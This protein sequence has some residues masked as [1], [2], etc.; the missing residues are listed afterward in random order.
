M[1]P[2]SPGK[3]ITDKILENKGNYKLAYINKKQA[4]SKNK[5]KVGVEHASVEDIKNAL[6]SV[7]NV[8]YKGSSITVEQLL[9]RKLINFPNSALMRRKVCE[10]LAI[11]YAN[12]KTFLKYLN[13][14]GI[15]IE[16]IDELIHE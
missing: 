10:E 13:L 14:L 3:K 2:D 4:I 8:L 16:R 6:S 12:G 11:P 5:T 7:K 1:K 9:K 15:S